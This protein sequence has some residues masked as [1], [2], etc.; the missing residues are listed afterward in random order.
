MKIYFFEECKLTLSKDT[1]ITVSTHPYIMLNVKWLNSTYDN[2]Q[3]QRLYTKAIK[4][5]SLKSWLFSIIFCKKKRQLVLRH[6][7][8]ALLAGTSLHQF[9]W[10]E[11]T[12]RLS[13]STVRPLTPVRPPNRRPQVSPRPTQ[14]GMG[15]YKPSQGYPQQYVII[16][17]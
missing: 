17:R 15:C 3:V 14:S 4:T 9:L 2:R 7:T 12:E 11:A 10:G 13:I 5:R 1:E 8:K 16:A 6:F